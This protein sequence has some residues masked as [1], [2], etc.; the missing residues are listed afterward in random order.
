V[1]VGDGASGTVSPAATA[2]EQVAG[3]GRRGPRGRVDREQPLEHRGERARVLRSVRGLG[4]D[5]VQ[6]RVGVV[7]EAE[8][9]RALHRGVQRGAQREHVGRGRRGAA[10]GDLGGQERGGA[11]DEAGAG[12]LHVVD[13]AGH[14][15]VGELDPPVGADEDVA[16]LDVAVH[17]AR[18]VRGGQPVGHVAADRGDAHR[19]ERALLPH[20][21]GQRVGRQVLHHEPR[22]VVVHH[23]VEH[24][25]DVRVL[26]PGTD[27][28]F[29]QD[30]LAGLLDLGR[31][32]A[33]G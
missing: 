32:R 20:D 18:G 3:L 26:Q 1:P 16:R 23:D 27:T 30:P 9:R 31:V 7:V 13:R 17:H 19:Q 4:G 11:R 21:G 6:Q 8:R 14:P 24:A 25:D 29:A 28:A 33:R 15:E 22:P 2:G 5:L 12:E 10:L